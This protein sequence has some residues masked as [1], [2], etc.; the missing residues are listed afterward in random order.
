MYN[1]RSTERLEKN[2]LDKIVFLDLSQ[3]SRS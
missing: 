2:G 1:K 3:R